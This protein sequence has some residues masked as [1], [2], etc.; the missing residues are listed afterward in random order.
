MS[1]RKRPIATSEQRLAALCRLAFMGLEPHQA[2]YMLETF[3]G[4]SVAEA[5]LIAA[6]HISE[7]R[8]RLGLP[9]MKKGPRTTNG[10]PT[11]SRYF[12]RFPE[13]RP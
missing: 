3:T 4:E 9:K 6:P 8:R 10:S 13:A 5:T 1:V 12:P 2:R 11:T 7:W